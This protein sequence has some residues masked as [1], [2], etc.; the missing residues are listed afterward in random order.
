MI[1]KLL[2]LVILGGLGY[3]GYLV[4]SN[5]STDERAVVTK[6]VGEVASDAKELAHKAADKLTDNAKDAIKKIDDKGKG[7]D[8]G[9][10]AEKS[11][12]PPRTP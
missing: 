3:V 1:K 5:L 6:K 12:D 9:A 8:G 2:F 7:A 11:P 4:W 10:A